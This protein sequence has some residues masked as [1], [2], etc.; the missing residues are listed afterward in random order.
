M[1]TTTARAS[2]LALL[3]ALCLCAARAQ[4]AAD[5]ETPAASPA[6]TRPNV[7][8]VVIDDLG[9]EDLESVPVPNIDALAA[10]GRSY[11]SFYVHPSCTP[12]RY[13]LQFGRQGLRDGVW[14]VLATHSEGQI[15]ADR[16]RRSIGSALHDAGFA[17]ALFGKWHLSTLAEFPDAE[18]VGSLADAARTFGYEHWLAGNPSNLTR[19][20]IHNHRNWERGDDGVVTLSQ[21]YASEA[22]VDAFVDWWKK[23][24]E[25]PRFAVVNLF[26]PHT[27]YTH[28]PKELIANGHEF[29][30]TTREA[31]ENCVVAVDTLIGRVAA[32]VD[33]S[34]TYLIVLSDNGTPQSDWPVDAR[35]RGYKHTVWQ[36][37]V[38]VPLIVVGPNVV[39]G[40]SSH[41]VHVVDVPATLLELC[42]APA[43]PS[44]ADSAS[45]AQS[46]V[47]D[48]PARAPVV[49]LGRKMKNPA[50]ILA[51]AIDAEGWKYVRTDEEQSLFHLPTDPFEA[52][53]IEDEE[54]VA[55]LRAELRRY[56]RIAQDLE[57]GKSDER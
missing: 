7:V 30:A 28:P 45:F 34:N 48:A 19:L 43:E 21:E 22:V 42:G 1:T 40:P 13:A 52:T 8:V 37:G 9:R 12:S 36:G 17:T 18:G 39:Q 46:L 16:S 14:S 51:A 24:E 4:D 56:I 50:P 2:I 6:P 49:V 57:A 32:A 11:T 38:N 41:L 31:F 33:T 26:A 44:F 54:R 35:S 25:R 53:P 27:P 3:L 47:G 10:R 23:D 29:P 20:D 5:A 55:V 15:G